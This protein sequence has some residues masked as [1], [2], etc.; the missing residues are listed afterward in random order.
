M[1]SPL[2]GIVTVL[3]VTACLINVCL[4]WCVVVVREVSHN[5]LGQELGDFDELL[6]QAIDGLLIH[7]G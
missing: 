4:G 1:L 5:V 7:V 6:T 2:H 3:L